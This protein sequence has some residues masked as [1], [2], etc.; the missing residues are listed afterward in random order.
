[1]SNRL[2][3]HNLDLIPFLL[4]FQKN[5]EIKKNAFA[6]FSG[7]YKAGKGCLRLTGYLKIKKG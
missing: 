3:V 1:M 7:K 4:R 6:Q 2:S 5:L